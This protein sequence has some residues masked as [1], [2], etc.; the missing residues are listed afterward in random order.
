MLTAL[1]G[2]DGKIQWV[3]MIMQ[4]TAPHAIQNKVHNSSKDKVNALKVVL[5]S[6]SLILL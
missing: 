1:R 5:S 2:Q 3:R 4:M 6:S